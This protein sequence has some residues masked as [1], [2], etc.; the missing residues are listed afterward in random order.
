MRYEEKVV[1]DF[2]DAIT[3]GDLPDE[4]LAPDMKAWTTTQGDMDKASYQQVVRLLRQIS[5][6]PLTFVIDSVT[7]EEDRIVAELHSTG[8]VLINDETYEN[9]YVFVFRVRD[10]KITSVAEHFNALIVQEKLMPVVAE[11]RK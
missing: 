4:M 7:A 2:F 9:T 1:R 11:I 10:G 8:G 5:K 6:V 3:A